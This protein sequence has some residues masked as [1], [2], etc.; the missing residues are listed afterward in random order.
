M[1]NATIVFEPSRRS[2]NWN[3]CGSRAKSQLNCSSRTA[4]YMETHPNSPT[5]GGPHTLVWL[6]RGLMDVTGPP[7]LF[8]KSTREW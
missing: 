4:T 8:W 7:V 3:I 6:A 1:R 2:T 5:N